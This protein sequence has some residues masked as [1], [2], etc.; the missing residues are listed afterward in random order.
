[1][2]LREIHKLTSR[3]HVY[4]KMPTRSETAKTYGK[5]VEYA[6]KATQSYTNRRLR[7]TCAELVVGEGKTADVTVAADVADTPDAEETVAGVESVAETLLEASCETC[8]PSGSTA[9]RITLAETCSGRADAISSGR[10]ASRG[11]WTA[12]REELW[13]ERHFGFI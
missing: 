4:P 6:T 13:V 8:G 3:E 10:P 5:Y 2:V 1:M 7:L 9:I 11:G 12:P